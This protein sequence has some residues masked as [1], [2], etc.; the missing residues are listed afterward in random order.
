MCIDVASVSDLDGFDR[1]VH[2][3]HDQ[4]PTATLVQGPAADAEND[5]TDAVIDGFEAL[6]ETR[7]LQ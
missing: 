6:P 7:Q 3:A 5:G 2:H 1:E 4:N